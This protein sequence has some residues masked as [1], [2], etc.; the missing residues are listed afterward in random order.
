MSTETPMIP[1]SQE[2]QEVT[3]ELL[4]SSETARNSFNAGIAAYCEGGEMYVTW[5][6]Y[7]RA[8]FAYAQLH[9]EDRK[10]PTRA[11][12]R[13]FEHENEFLAST[14][15]G[16]L[17][18]QDERELAIARQHKYMALK[19][20][21]YMSEALEEHGACEPARHELDALSSKLRALDFGLEA[22]K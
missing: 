19:A 16:L 2:F 7:A 10:E 9:N 21:Q 5:N 3:Q 13:D 1:D 11:E 17:D 18:S 4:N 15:R 8:G 6:I 20:L 12:M 14:M 22:G